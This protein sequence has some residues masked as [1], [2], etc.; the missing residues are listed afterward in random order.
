MPF[1]YIVVP[2]LRERSNPYV[3]HMFCELYKREILW[4]N[5]MMRMLDEYE[6]NINITQYCMGRILFRQNRHSAQYEG[7]SI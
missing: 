2:H 1:P 5:K 3:V 6:S 4:R 7:Q